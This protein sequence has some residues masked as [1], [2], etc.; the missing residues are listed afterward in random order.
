MLK[1]HGY[2]IISI[3]WM[4]KWRNFANGVGPEPGILDNTSLIKKIKRNRIKYNNPESDSDIGLA[5]KQDY[6]IISVGFFKFFYDTFGCDSIVVLKYTILTEEVEIN[7]DPLSQ[8]NT[9]KRNEKQRNRNQ[10]KILKG[11]EFSA[12]YE[13]MDEVDT[14]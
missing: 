12:I 1:T 9:F 5:D 8:S 13:F 3:D 10:P 2:F 6:Y 11:R 14:D 7:H 4:S